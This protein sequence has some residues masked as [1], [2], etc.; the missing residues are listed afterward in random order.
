[1]TTG[2][3]CDGEW[4]IDAVMERRDSWT[5]HLLQAPGLDP[6][7]A[8]FRY[9]NGAAHILAAVLCDAVGQPVE[10]FAGEALFEP[11]GIRPGGWP[12]DPDGIAYGFGHLHLSARDLVKLGELY[13]RGGDQI[14]SRGYVADA[15]R[16]HVGGGPPEHL[17]YGLL[18]WIDEPRFLA[19]GYAGQFLI[20]SPGDELVVVGT[21]DAA[22][23]SPTWTSARHALAQ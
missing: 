14:V 17:P 8:R 9:D 13:L 16:A 18:W 10:E 6:P 23:L 19:A 4:D 11:L 7:G 1:M 21:G 5:A 3:A 15:T 22:R 12:V 20:V 2:R